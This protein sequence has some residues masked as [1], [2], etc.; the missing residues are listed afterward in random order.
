RR[1]YTRLSCRQLLWFASHLSRWLM[2]QGLGLC[3]LSDERVDSFL[4]ARR[5]TGYT[6]LLSR[7]RLRPILHF[8]SEAHLLPESSPAPPLT[9]LEQLLAD[10]EGSLVHD[11]GLTCG[12]A[13]G[14][15][16][17]ARQLLVETSR[18]GTL[19]LSPLDGAAVKHY[20]L[21]SSRG[22][23]LNQTRKTLSGL[24]SFLRFLHLRGD[25][26]N[27]LRGAVPKIAGWRMASLPKYLAA[28]Q[29][30]AI[31][32]SC[33][34]RLTVGRRDY[35]VL[36]LLARMG[37]RAKEVAALSLDD[38]YWREGVLLIRGKG[39]REDRMPLMAEVGSALASYL[40]RRRKTTCRS[41][42]LCHRAPHTPLCSDTVVRIVWRACSRAQVPPV[43]A[44][45]LRH[46]AA[47]TML[48]RGATM[49][50]I[51]QTLRHRCH[52]TTAIYAKVDHCRLR[53]LAQPWPGGAI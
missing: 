35:A 22:S 23:S 18:S 13:S 8:F 9:P 31:V 52:A 41:L 19:D 17:V 30:N 33:D 26:A 27:D 7:R 3:D 20:V 53:E 2:K 25:I 49:D 46:S 28:E 45:R 6:P 16:A 10:Y 11:R 5:A 4:C 1:G 21:K 44:H 48:R 50:E 51:S 37:L 36:L 39:G 47:T 15:R 38:V 40:R 43:G 29:V 12:V 14:Y 42:F 34:R 32:N 24:R